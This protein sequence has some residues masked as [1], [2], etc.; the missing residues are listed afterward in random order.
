MRCLPL[1]ALT[2]GIVLSSACGPSA[3][4]GQQPSWRTTT[5]VA[6][7]RSE[8]PAPR[9]LELA[10]EGPAARD[11]NPAT[12]PEAPRFPLADAVR[13]AVDERSAELGKPS[14]QPDAR[15]YAVARELAEVTPEDAPLAYRLVEFALQRHGIIEPSPHLVVIWGP[16]DDPAS[17]LAQLERRLGGLLSERD[18]VRLG[19]GTARRGAA[20]D[21]TVLAFQT[22]YLDTQPIPRVVAAGGVARI[23][24]RL[25]PGFTDPHL[26]VT[27]EDGAVDRPTLARLEDGGFRAAVACGGHRGRQQVEITASDRSGSSVLANFPIWCGA[28][29]PRSVS[30]DLA[31][32]DSVPIASAEEA[33][34][35]MLALVNRDRVAHGLPPLER[36]P[37]L[38]RVA[39]AHSQDMIETGVVAHVSER[40]GDASDRVRAGGIK[41]SVVL[42][43]V[44]RAYGVGEAQEG[45]MNSPGHRANLLAEE[46]THVGIGIVLGE[47]VAGRRELFVTQVF[48]RVPGP[49]DPAGATRTVAS[50]VQSLRSLE[51]DAVLGTIAQ[52][53]AREVASGVST[54]DA[55]A[56]AAKRLDQAARHLSRVTTLMTTVAD[57]SAFDPAG[58]LRDAGL[59]H[60]GVGVAQ[61]DH[62]VMGEGAIYVVVLLGQR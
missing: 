6:A 26:F 61:G 35:R 51:E 19:I 29:P 7:S 41:T 31:G 48:S 15:L 25:E 44:A 11:Y 21:V 14:P 32:D 36:D 10:P 43:N 49:I 42:E 13:A 23:E 46:A 57:L 47:E 9:I 5:E 30:V 55:G 33:E 45:L 58:S 52:G 38:T 16:I 28:E 37:R 59:T 20:G 56:R 3:A 22:S 40:T 27:R 50:V 8:A 62:D 39:R 53:F 12:L 18:F 1:P 2:L 24:G 54:A 34:E 4:P 60:F 17:I